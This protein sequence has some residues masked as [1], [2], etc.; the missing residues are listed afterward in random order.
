[1]A[2]A[3]GRTTTD[4]D[5]AAFEQHSLPYSVALHLYPGLVILALYLIAAPR[6][7]ALGYPP[8]LAL[9]IAAVVGVGLLQSGHLL[10]LW[11]ARE[12]RGSAHTMAILM[13]RVPRAPLWYYIVVPVG[14][15]VIAFVVLVLTGP[16]DQ[17]MLSMMPWLPK[18]YNFGD[19]ELY[20]GYAPEAIRTTLRLR[21][22][23]D[24]LLL[25]PIEE[26][27]FRG[28]LM[29]RISR[30][31]RWTPVVHHA[32]FTMYH[33]WQPFNYPTIFLG[34]L[35]V[36]YVVWKTR[37]IRYS[38]VAHVLVNVIGGLSTYGLLVPS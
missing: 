36:T 7:S 31:G 10:I 30:Y 9:L 6:V 22:V 13:W 1:M 8:L 15:I 12:R 14:L 2:L 23:I 18:W 33:F 19:P 5:A 17:W 4:P 37:D 29:P 35:P 32:L 16:L 25:P 20:S 38:I 21:L 26:L 27:Y 24:G 3:L 28:Y 34:I 11:M